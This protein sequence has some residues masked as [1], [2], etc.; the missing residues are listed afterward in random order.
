M[1][2]VIEF[3]LPTHFGPEV[4]W[5]VQEH[6]GKVIAFISHQEKSAEKV[7]ASADERLKSKSSI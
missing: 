4:K 7:C 2:Q 1:A 5:L 3:Y 6:L